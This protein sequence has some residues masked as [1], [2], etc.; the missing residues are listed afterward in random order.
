MLWQ[1]KTLAAM[2]ESALAESLEPAACTNKVGSLMS[3]LGDRVPSERVS[4]ERV[5]SERM[6]SE[7][8]TSEQGF[9][10]ASTRTGQPLSAEPKQTM[11]IKA[12][13]M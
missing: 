12:L 11:G 4:S 10:A 9:S 3:P 7:R 1:Q 5:T 2:E 13:W 8:M 6:S